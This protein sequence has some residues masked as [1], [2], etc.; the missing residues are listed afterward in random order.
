MHGPNQDELEVKGERGGEGGVRGKEWRAEK[1]RLV[2]EDDNVRKMIK[3]VPH[4]PRSF[5]DRNYL[6]R[7]Q[8]VSI[9]I[10]LEAAGFVVK[11]LTRVVK[12]IIAPSAPVLY[13]NVSQ[14]SKEH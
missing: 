14:K 3:H 8:E 7:A 10:G 9:G 4:P 2:C 12:F 6:G 1:H 13:F 11:K 5:S